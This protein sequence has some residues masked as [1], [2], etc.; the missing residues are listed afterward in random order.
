M[1]SS[2]VL[3]NKQVQNVKG[4][5]AILWTISHAYHSN[6]TTY[7]G[8]RLHAQS[9]LSKSHRTCQRSLRLPSLTDASRNS[10]SV[11]YLP[12]PAGSGSV[13]CWMGDS[14]KPHFPLPFCLWVGE[15]IA[16][17]ESTGRVGQTCQTGNFAL[18]CAILAAI[19]CEIG[20]TR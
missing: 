2:K 18:L 3:Q 9:R 12:R 4:F 1:S 6:G 16:L 10:S 17:N 13:S 5:L 8:S 14:R 15:P 20:T 11:A 19:L 7:A